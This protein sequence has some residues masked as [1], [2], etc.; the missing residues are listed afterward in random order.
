MPK[1]KTPFR[2]K[3]NDVCVYASKSCVYG[4]CR[5]VQ[6]I[7]NKEDNSN[8]YRIR[9]SWIHTGTVQ[10]FTVPAEQVFDCEDCLPWGT[11]ANAK[12]PNL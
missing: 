1:N 12:I 2:F 10:I 11:Y 9:L 5:I 7:R 8:S 3:Q 4:Y 6:A